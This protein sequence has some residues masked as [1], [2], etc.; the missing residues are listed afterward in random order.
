MK[1]IDWKMPEQKNKLYSSLDEEAILAVQESYLLHFGLTKEYKELIYQ[2]KDKVD[3]KKSNHLSFLVTGLIL[4]IFAGVF[5]FLAFKKDVTGIKYF[6]PV[7]FEFFLSVIA[8]VF[9]AIFLFIAI[10]GLL[11]DHR[12]NKEFQKKFDSIRMN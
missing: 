12:K 3:R 1:K 2:E 11:C 7:S 8:L 10:K 5:F 9:M 6:T 4:S